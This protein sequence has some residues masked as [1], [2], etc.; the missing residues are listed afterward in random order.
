[1]NDLERLTWVAEHLTEFTIGPH[2]TT[3]KYIVDNGFT[4]GVLFTP[5]PHM[6]PID[7]LNGCIEKAMI[8]SIIL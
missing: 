2:N 3:L 5:D 1:M 4:K 8:A 7:I 6:E